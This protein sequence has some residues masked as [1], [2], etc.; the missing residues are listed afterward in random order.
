MIY[1]L[2]NWLTDWLTDWLIDWLMESYDGSNV[3]S[4]PGSNERRTD[5]NEWRNGRFRTKYWI[6]WHVSPPSAYLV[7]LFPFLF[8]FRLFLRLAHPTTSYPLSPPPFPSFRLFS[9]FFFSTARAK[10][11]RDRRCSRRATFA[12]CDFCSPCSRLLRVARWD[13]RWLATVVREFS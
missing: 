11:G 6:L 12:L 2:T 10:W 13:L 5:S 1:L 7:L 8:L 4:L 3:V 9:L